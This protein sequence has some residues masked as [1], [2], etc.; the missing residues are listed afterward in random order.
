M[1][2]EGVELPYLRLLRVR[3]ASQGIA[4]LSSLGPVVS[5]PLKHWLLRHVA[6]VPSTVTATLAEATT[7]W[8]T[9]LLVTTVGTVTAVSLLADGDQTLTF[10]FV[11]VLAAA[12]LAFLLTTSRSVLSPLAR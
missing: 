7:Y 12:P 2:A 10:S 9:A 6:P 4:Y 11:C 3:L 8:M 5:E 1:R